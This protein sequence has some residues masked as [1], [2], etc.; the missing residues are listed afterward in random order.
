MH[1]WSNIVANLFSWTIW[2]NSMPPGN[3]VFDILCYIANIYYRNSVQD[4][5][6]EYNICDE[7]I[8]LPK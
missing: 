2:M 4:I 7:A 1:F 3:Y 5:V 8:Y 6:E